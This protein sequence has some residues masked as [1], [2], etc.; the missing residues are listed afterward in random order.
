MERRFQVK[1]YT[2]IGKG[3]GGSENTREMRSYVNTVGKVYFIP[4]VM[5]GATQGQ[6]AKRHFLGA[7]L[8]ARSARIVRGA[9]DG[10]FASSTVPRNSSKKIRVQRY[11]KKSML[12]S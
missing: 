3:V 7:F 4:T 9:A 12:D 2:R 5:R 10:N 11:V 6:S 1:W 8:P